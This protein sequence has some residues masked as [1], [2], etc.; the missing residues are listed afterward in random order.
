MRLRSSREGV[1]AHFGNGSAKISRSHALKRSTRKMAGWFLKDVD[2]STLF[3]PNVDGG[4]IR[5]AYFVTDATIE[6]MR[7]VLGGIDRGALE[8]LGVTKGSA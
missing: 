4:A 8:H 2:C 6:L 5:G 7:Q 3:P 1:A